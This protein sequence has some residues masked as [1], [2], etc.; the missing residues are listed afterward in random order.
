[1]RQ[2]RDSQGTLAQDLPRRRRRSCRRE[3]A[4]R[5]SRS[6]SSDKDLEVLNSKISATTL[7]FGDKG[8]KDA[9]G[10]LAIFGRDLKGE[11]AASRIEFYAREGKGAAYDLLQQIK[12]GK[13]KLKE[14]K[15]AE[16]PKELQGKTETEQTV[17]LEKL[18]KER[19]ELGKEAVE[20][21]KKRAA[22]IA[23]KQRE[24]EK[25]RP[26]DSFDNQVLGILRVQ[27]ARAHIEYAAPPAEEKKK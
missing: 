26:R 19:Q 3:L 20:L 8:K 21:S 1:M 25:L 5:S 9:D 22:Y 4:A 24:D 17:I 18:D 10:A 7:C 27:A 2:Q 11:A 14:I 23:E 13:V 16:L 12:D 6:R 15:E